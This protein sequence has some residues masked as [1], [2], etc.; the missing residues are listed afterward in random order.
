MAATEIASDL[1]V[2]P[3]SSS[4]SAPPTACALRTVERL[5]RPIRIGGRRWADRTKLSAH[6]LTGIAPRWR[7][8]HWLL[9]FATAFI[10]SRPTAT[11]V[12]FAETQSPALYQRL[13][14]DDLR[15]REALLVCEWP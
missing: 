15:E 10:S 8:A 3:W 5:T 13:A 2:P 1:S 14:L 11:M 6:A 4:N 12:S 9:S 7:V